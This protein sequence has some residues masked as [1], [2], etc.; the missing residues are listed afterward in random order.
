MNPSGSIGTLPLGHFIIII[1]III[2]LAS[3]YTGSEEEWI[4]F[5]SATN[6]SEDQ[7]DEIGVSVRT[8]RKAFNVLRMPMQDDDQSRKDCLGL[9]THT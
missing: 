3:T 9:K 7:Q 2:P 8:P 5:D 6:Q 1:R 4:R